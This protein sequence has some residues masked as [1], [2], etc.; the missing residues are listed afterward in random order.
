MPARCVTL[1][2]PVF[3]NALSSLMWKQ[4]MSQTLALYDTRRGVT[5]GNRQCCSLQ[6]SV[7]DN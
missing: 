3:A 4:W 6:H 7:Y 5:Q 1:C 2:E